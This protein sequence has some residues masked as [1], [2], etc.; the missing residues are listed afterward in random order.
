MLASSGIVPPSGKVGKNTKIIVTT[1]TTVFWL[2]S[3]GSQMLDT[4]DEAGQEVM[5]VSIML[6][7]PT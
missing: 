1:H 4:F 3:H 5:L 7:C 2:C 6:L